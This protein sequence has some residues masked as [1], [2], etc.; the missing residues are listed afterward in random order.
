MTKL[1][2]DL[3]IKKKKMEEQE[4]KEKKRQRDEEEAIDQK[5]KRDKEWKS[6]WEVRSFS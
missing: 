5:A 6:E 3:E 4:S 2:A 1:F